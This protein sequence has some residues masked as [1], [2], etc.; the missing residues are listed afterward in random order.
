[1]ITL[2]VPA[3]NEEESIAELVHALCARVQF[4]EGYEILVVNDGSADATGTILAGLTA[5]V[6][7]LRVITH[8]RNMGLGCALQTGFRAAKGRIIV[9]MDADLTHPPELIPQLVQACDTDFVVASRYV[10]GGGMAGVPW[11]RVLLSQIAN[12][13]FRLCFWTKL[14]D[15]TAGFKAYHADSVQ[16]LELTSRGFE[17][18]L[19]ITVRLLAG[20]ASFREIPYVLTTRQHGESKMNYGKLLP[21]Y[22]RTLMTMLALRWGRKEQHHA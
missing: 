9:T 16:K 5:E 1:M 4:P 11:W 15:I 2:L 7:E 18:Q 17:T 20:G 22:S 14:R 12:G 13:I 10:R 6:P 3:Y 21:V 19:E 8:P